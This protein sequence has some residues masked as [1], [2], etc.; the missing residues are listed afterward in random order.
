MSLAS[1]AFEKALLGPVEEAIEIRHPKISDFRQERRRELRI[2][3]VEDQS[4]KDEWRKKR[5]QKNTNKDKSLAEELSHQFRQR[6]P[7]RAL[8]DGHKW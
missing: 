6:E 4:N 1:R 2:E 5:L 8:G 7:D 3:I